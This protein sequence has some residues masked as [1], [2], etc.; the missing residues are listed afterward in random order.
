MNIYTQIKNANT[1]NLDKNALS[2]NM[3]SGEITKITYST[4]FQKVEKTSSEISQ[5]G[6][7][8]GDKV[9]II[10]ENNPEWV[11]TYLA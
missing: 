3:D 8:P 7:T 4:L 9:A 2:M 5:L 1:H 6:L 11:I 10:A